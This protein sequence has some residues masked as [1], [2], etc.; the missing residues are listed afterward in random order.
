MSKILNYYFPIRDF[1]YIL[2]LEEYNLSRY[3]KQVSAR[4][5]K[6]NFEIRDQLVFTGRIKLICGLAFT[7]ILVIGFLTYQIHATVFTFFIVAI[8]LLT[9]LLLLLASALVELPVTMSRKQTL[10]RAKNF[11]IKNYPDTKIVGITGSFGKTTTKYLLQSVLKYDFTVAIIPDNINTALGIANYI[12]QKKLPTKIDLLI[13]EMGAY[14]Q[15]DI[16]ETATLLPPD[17]AIITILGDQHLER[18]G[19]KAHLIKGKSEIFTTNR[20]TSCYVTAIDFSLIEKA[21][22]ETNQL[23]SVAVPKGKKS[24][25]YLVKKLAAD[26]GVGDESIQAS[27]ASFVTPERRN[28]Q[29]V[30]QG[31]TII[32]N[33]YNISPMVAE[34]MLKEAAAVAAAQNKRLVVMTAGIGEQGSEGPAANTQFAIL[35]NKYASRVI[36]HPSIFITH[37]TP[38][39]QIPHVFTDMG[40]DV[41]EQPA[42]WLD[43]T[44]EL[45]LWLTDHSDL[46]YL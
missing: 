31:V 34:T 37:I 4:L 2:Q 27:C 18:F 9:P 41:S 23:Q 26:L 29:I 8:P 7:I 24:T 6:R 42:T 22:I 11:F 35:L 17:L 28:N 38:T 45:L 14:T 13:V 10:I 5:F 40:L 44:Q 33:S 12:L 16:K 21:D 19:S 32:D 46:A 39:L 43:G 15:G 1:L 30:R 3:W 36:L 20:N 25:E